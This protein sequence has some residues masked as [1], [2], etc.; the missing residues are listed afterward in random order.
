VLITETQFLYAEDP[1]ACGLAQVRC[2]QAVARARRMENDPSR[3]AALYRQAHRVLSGLAGLQNDARVQRMQADC[4]E[5]EGRA[6]LD[7]LQSGPPPRDRAALVKRLLPLEERFRQ[8]LT[9]RENLPDPTP[10]D[11]R[12]L[13]ADRAELARLAGHLGR[14]Q[15]A[16]RLREHALKEVDALVQGQPLP[17]D[18][19]VLA[20]GLLTLASLDQDEALRRRALDAAETLV[21]RRGSCADRELL[22]RCCHALA[23][24][25]V[26]PGQRDEAE[27]LEERERAIRADLPQS[28]DPTTP[29][30]RESLRVRAQIT[31][32]LMRRDREKI[33]QACAQILELTDRRLALRRHLDDLRSAAE[34]LDLLLSLCGYHLDSDTKQMLYKR[35]IALYSELTGRCALPGDLQSLYKVC[36]DLAE[37]LLRLER[38]EEARALYDRMAALDAQLRQLPTAVKAHDG[39]LQTQLRA[40]KIARALGLWADAQALLQRAQALSEGTGDAETVLAERTRLLEAMGRPGEACGEWY[41][42]LHRAE[43]QVLPD[44]APTGYYLTCAQELLRLHRLLDQPQAA[45]EL[46]LRVL[47]P[48]S[49]SLL[50]TRRDCTD[51]FALLEQSVPF[52]DLLAGQPD[53]LE[54]LCSK[55]PAVI[56]TLVKAQDGRMLAHERE[57]LELL[58]RRCAECHPA[59]SDPARTEQAGSLLCELAEPAARM[60]AAVRHPNGETLRRETAALWEQTV[61][62]LGSGDARCAPLLRE[63]AAYARRQADDQMGSPADARPW[64][65]QALRRRLQAAAFDPTLARQVYEDCQALTMVLAQTDGREAALMAC[66]D[67]AAELEALYA[68]C[69]GAADGLGRCLWWLGKLLADGQHWAES[70]TR[71]KRAAALLTDC[72]GADAPAADRLI[73]ANCLA[74]ILLVQS[75]T[76][77]EEPAAPWTERLARETD[78]LLAEEGDHRSDFLLVQ[79]C[80]TLA[81]LPGIPKEARLHHA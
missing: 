74:G 37:L 9:L 67:T 23:A 48:L 26:L 71:H 31:G 29:L 46:W 55:T 59:M 70:L 3:A 13:A 73:L 76:G 32:S 77:Q 12:T 11:R 45:A 53:R 43:D 4:L 68:R 27:A 44:G 30:R 33:R 56:R 61:E 75:L 39:A 8:A 14:E 50:M 49:R 58:L 47:S 15:E 2:F 57:V 10:E 35:R 60:A 41:S 80:Y 21:E 19:A 65:E 25:L 17:D 64:L 78:R 62:R 24:C 69:P 22:A 7:A 40:A 51:L 16:R 6:S 18:L 20:E 34:K 5:A 1:V 38:P 52:F 79:C 42:A 66:R 36:A 81:C 54:P 28:E 63:L 72:I